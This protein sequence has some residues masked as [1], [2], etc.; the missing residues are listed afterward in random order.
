MFD[1]YT[2]VNMNLNKNHIN[3]K[4]EEM[5]SDM[6]TIC[7]LLSVEANI[8]SSKDVAKKILQYISKYDRLLYSEISV[9]YFSNDDDTDESD[10]RKAIQNTQRLLDYILSSE[11]DKDFDNEDLEKLQKVVLKLWDH[12]QL[13]QYQATYL[14]KDNF[15]EHFYD[16]K[17]E[18]TEEIRDEG[19]KLNKELIS[20]VAIFTSMAFL[21]FGGLNSLSDILG[22]TIKNL[23]V[24]NISIVSLIWGLCIYN[25]IF[26]FL[27][28]VAKIIDTD[29]SSNYS[30]FFF[31]RHKVY[32]VG[33][34]ILL[35]ALALCGWLY[36]IK[37]DFQGWY[38]ELCCVYGC[39]A[40]FL[41]IIF[42]IC[43]VIVILV[44]YFISWIVNRIRIKNMNDEYLDDLDDVY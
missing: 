39:M 19:H 8:F 36:F 5:L 27:Y 26:L 10:S 44:C 13:A 24:L 43:I 21:V 23:P 40:K 2:Q 9:Y 17:N 29:I 18:I 33:N 22:S 20:L 32:I 14:N 3:S 28:L 11:S 1:K 6:R 4:T 16:E 34:A 42:M 25:I 30:D 37:V 15:Y 7:V 38:T 35:T 31:I 41:P 12:F